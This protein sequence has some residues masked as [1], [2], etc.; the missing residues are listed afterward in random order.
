MSDVPIS[1]PSPSSETPAS[2]AKVGLSLALVVV[3]LLAVM[4]IKAPR[5]D[6]A[7]SFAAVS[8]PNGDLFPLHGPPVAIH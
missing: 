8:D 7:R 4:A 6:A 1:N 2:P 3:A 5:A